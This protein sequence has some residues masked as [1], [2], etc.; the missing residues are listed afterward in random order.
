M[1]DAQDGVAP[2]RAIIVLQDERSRPEVRS[3]FL[4]WMDRVFESAAGGAILTLL[5]TTILGGFVS[6]YFTDSERRHVLSDQH[7][8]EQSEQVRADAVNRSNLLDAAAKIFAARRVYAGI[9]RSAID[10]GAPQKMLDT[11][12][13]DY[14]QA[15]IG[16][17]YGVFAFRAAALNYLGA[18]TSLSFSNV[19]EERISVSF[20]RIDACL[21]DAYFEY[22]KGHPAMAAATLHSCGADGDG[23]RKWDIA[24]EFSRLQTCTSTFEQELD[25]SIYIEN[26]FQRLPDKARSTDATYNIGQ[27]ADCGKKAN[28]VCLRQLNRIL[29]VKKLGLGCDALAPANYVLKPSPHGT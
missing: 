28:W 9:V 22:A 7:D 19:M 26:Y 27:L 29:V 6:F 13:A 21:T 12:W 25:Y 17:N 2:V 23:N 16:Y 11:R 18:K 14:Q 24:D 5:V 15:Y 8:K 10:H 20:S 1:P 4:G 3:G